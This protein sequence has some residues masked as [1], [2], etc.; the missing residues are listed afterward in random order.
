MKKLS[1]ICS[2]FAI[3]IMVMSCNNDDDNSNPDPTQASIIAE[4]RLTGETTGGVSETLTDCEKQQTFKFFTGGRVDFK[5]VDDNDGDPCGYD[6]ESVTYTL[7]GNILRISIPGAGSSGGTLIF[8]FE[9]QTLTETAL[10]LRL[11]GDNEEPIYLPTEVQILT[12]IKV[13]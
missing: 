8:N 1:L 13:T 5:V 11:T 10:V 3:F 12:F 6:T 2:L 4:W 7:S 9:I